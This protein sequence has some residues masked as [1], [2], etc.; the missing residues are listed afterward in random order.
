MQSEVKELVA[1]RKE[2][3]RFD[4]AYEAT[5]APL[6]TKRDALQAQITEELKKMGVLSQRFQNATVTLSV[7]KSVQVVD[8]AKAVEAL[9][10]RGLADYVAETLTPLFWNSAAKE[11]AKQGDTDIPGL[12]VQEKNTCL[13]GRVTKR[14][15]E[16]NNRLAYGHL[17]KHEARPHPSRREES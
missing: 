1:L 9:K 14:N 4:L 12:V 6:K 8:E 10:G 5:V 17:R 3:G 15:E 16:S 2:I 7:R 11:I 13:S